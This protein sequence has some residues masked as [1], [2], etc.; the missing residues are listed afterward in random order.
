M[1][2]V[3]CGKEFA[4]DYGS[5]DDACKTAEEAVFK[6][7]LKERWRF[8]VKRESKAEPSYEIICEECADKRYAGLYRRTGHPAYLKRSIPVNTPMAR[9]TS[10][11]EFSKDNIRRM[12]KNAEKMKEKEDGE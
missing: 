8:L 6:T 12:K 11:S 10:E 5:G 1:K 4:P 2:C 3:D 9:T 7:F